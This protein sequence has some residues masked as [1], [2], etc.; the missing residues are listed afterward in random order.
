MAG[1][2]QEREHATTWQ[3][4]A[5]ATAQN[6]AVLIRRVGEKFLI[7][8]NAEQ[9]YD[10][11]YMA[12]MLSQDNP[13]KNS[14]TRKAFADQ[15]AWKEKERLHTAKVEYAM[16]QDAAEAAKHVDIMI[17]KIM[18]ATAAMVDLEEVV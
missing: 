8:Q 15:V 13:G 11:A 12:G 2:T 16:A 18:A 17:M 7:L 3:Q 14:E 5:F 10:G 4:R 1:R 6:T 9:D